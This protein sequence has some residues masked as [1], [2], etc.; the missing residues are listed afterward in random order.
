MSSIARV[1]RGNTA[2]GDIVEGAPSAELFDIPKHS[3]LQEF[4]SKVL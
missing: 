3:R 1:L 2:D 4:L